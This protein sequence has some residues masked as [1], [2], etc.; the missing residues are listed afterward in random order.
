MGTDKQ[1]CLELNQFGVLAGELKTPPI[2][3]TARAGTITALLGPAGSGKSLIIESLAGVRRPGV[4][5]TGYVK[6]PTYALVPQ[7]ARLSVLP[8]DRVHTV[9]GLNGWALQAERLVGIRPAPSDAEQATTALLEQLRLDS[10]RIAHLPFRDLS[11]AERRRV[12]LCAALQSN[13]AVLFFDGWDEVMD[14]ADRRAIASV[15]NNR[16]QSGLILVLSGRRLPFEGLKPATH[17]ELAKDVPGEHPVP[18]LS[19]NAPAEGHDF[20]L[21][22]VN[23]LTVARGRTGIRRSSPAVAVDGASLYVRHNESVALLGSSGAGKTTLLESLAGLHSPTSGTILVTGHD[24]THAAGRRARRL[25]RDVQLV[26]QDATAVLDGS[27]TVRSHLQEALSMTRGKKES[28]ALWLE[29]LGLSPR[30]LPVPAD[31]LSTSESQR[32]DL[33]R[34]LALR[35]SLV[36]YDSPEVSAAEADDGLIA[37]VIGSAKSAGCAFLFA[38]S[39]PDIASS[40]ADR[41]AIMHSGRIIELGSRQE[42]LGSPAHPVTRALLQGDELPPEDPTVS[43]SGCPHVSQCAHRQLPLCNEKEPMLAPL[44]SLTRA[45]VSGGTG[46][47][48]VACFHPIEP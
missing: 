46:S 31:Q 27:R 41:I 45:A 15:L 48:R 43:H 20:P 2:S 14:G 9:V 38:T 21:L 6:S 5:A 17:I 25:R 30:L 10:K 26:F 22:E 39:R 47:R 42:V 13:P 3:L 44:A 34:S 8:T 4:E 1:H 11:A 35:P 28:P 36:L 33:A 23:R 32:V 24:V 29:K 40:L 19:R 18:L 37:S 12:L 16:L 7:D